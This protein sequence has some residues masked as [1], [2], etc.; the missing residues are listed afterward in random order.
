MNK[1]SLQWEQIRVP[2][3][4]CS[5]EFTLIRN[6][7]AAVPGVVSVHADYLERMVRV[8][9]DANHVQPPALLSQIDALGF[10]ARISDGSQVEVETFARGWKD[11]TVAAGGICLAIAGMAYFAK[12]PASWTAVAAT[13]A[14]ILSAAPVVV[15][16]TR[17]IRGRRIDMNVLMVVAAVGALLIGERFEA[18]TA[19]FLFGIAIWLEDRSF[20]RARVAVRSL[21]ELVPEVAHRYARGTKLRSKASTTCIPMTSRTCIRI[22]SG[23]TMCFWCGQANASRW[24]AMFCAAIRQSWKRTLRARACRWKNRR[25]RRFLR[26]RKMGTRC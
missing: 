18:A 21:V 19:M 8:R 20:R 24:T 23:L 13:L 26:E 3:M 15:A 5:E 11:V 2:E 14:T 1:R 7:L 16:A 25:D 12:A 22:S 17:A 10:H 6:K 9:Y 4:D